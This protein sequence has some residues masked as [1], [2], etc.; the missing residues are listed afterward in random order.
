M[1]NHKVRVD[2]GVMAMKGYSTHLRSY[3][4]IQ[5]SVSYNEIIWILAVIIIFNLYSK[6]HIIKTFLSDLR[7]PQLYHLHC[8]VKDEGAIDHNTVTRWLKIFSLGCKN[9]NYQERSSW[10]KIV[11]S[12]TVLL[13]IKANPVSSIQW[14]LHIPVWFVT[15]TALTKASRAAKFCLILLKNCKTFDSPFEFM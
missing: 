12:E 15:F 1:Y 3:H 7:I 9:L 8:C 4:Q 13:A 10:S 6:N 2:L 5:L 11:G 14:A